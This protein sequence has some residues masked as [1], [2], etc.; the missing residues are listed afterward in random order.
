MVVVLFAG[1][2]DGQE[3]PSRV[4][5]AFNENDR[6]NGAFKEH[7]R[8]WRRIHPVASRKREGD[9]QTSGD[10]WH[11]GD[12]PQPFQAPSDI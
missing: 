4:D 8:T 12:V 2:G 5:I 10:D 7:D 11:L 1:S 6:G 3:P 9:T